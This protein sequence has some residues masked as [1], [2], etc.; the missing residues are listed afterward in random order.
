[1]HLAMFD[2]EH[3]YLVCNINGVGEVHRT[4]QQYQDVPDTGTKLDSPTIVSES[5]NAGTE[6]EQICV[7]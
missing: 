1:M 7:K 2:I 4:G 5:Q 6:F 3:I